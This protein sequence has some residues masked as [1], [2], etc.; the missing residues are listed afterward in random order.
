MVDP[1]TDLRRSDPLAELASLA[2][3]AGADVVGRTFQ[4]RE[5][6]DP[7]TFVGSGK[8]SELSRLARENRIDVLIFDHDLSPAQVRSLEKEIGRRVIDRTELILDIFATHARSKQAKLQVELAQLEYDLPRMAKMWS[9]I[10]GEQQAGGASGIG[11]RGPGE[12]QLE[13]DRRIA[14]KKITD[15]KREI[16]EIQKRK[17][18]EVEARGAENFTVSLVGYTN[19]GKSTLMNALTAAGV[20][21]E[22][23]LFSTLDT[24]TRIWALSSGIRTLLSDTVGFIRNLPHDLVTSFHA[25][26]EEVAQANLLLHVVDASHPEAEEQIASVNGVLGELGCKDSPTLLLLN[27]VDR[28]RDPVELTLLRNR[29]PGA[30]LISAATRAGLDEL[31][32]RLRGIV[33]D[34]LVDIV[35]D[36]PHSEGKLLAELAVH[37]VVLRKEY[38]NEHARMAMK[39][40]KRLLWKIEKYRVKDGA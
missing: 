33:A 29:H 20:L 3:T 15:L 18:R 7:R 6:P 12:Q 36:I 39:V 27:K 22:D 14:R 5:R 28:F 23:R 21:V 31:D 17:R 30:I 19:A 16:V 13:S 37:A 40:P 34:R 10:A 2:E 11:M 24:R 26:L 8:A 9:H 1:D 35:A 4:K 25:T 38:V 32:E